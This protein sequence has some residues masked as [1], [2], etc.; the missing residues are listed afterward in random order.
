[1]VYSHWLGPEVGPGPVLCGTFHTTQ[2]SRPENN[3]FSI[4]IGKCK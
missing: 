4:F 1:M 3:F 2:E